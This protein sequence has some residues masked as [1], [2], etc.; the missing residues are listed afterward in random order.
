MQ[1]RPV[2]RFRRELELHPTSLESLQ[3]LLP[4]AECPLSKYMLLSMLTH[5]L[6]RN[7]S[8]EIAFDL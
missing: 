7:P 1:V 5:F 8:T 2:D 6:R 4:L 3:E